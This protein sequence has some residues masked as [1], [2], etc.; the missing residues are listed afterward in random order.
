MKVLCFDIGGT[1]IKYG[2]IE[3]E[4]I[5]YKS[6][7]PTNYQLGQESVSN[8][9]LSVTKELME[10]HDFDGVGVSCAGCV[11][12]DYGEIVAGPENIK[13]FDNWNFKELFE[14]NCG[15]KVVADND[16]NCFGVAEGMTGAARKYNNYLTMTVGTG[17]GGA[18]VVNGEMWR[19]LNFR[20]AEFGRMLIEGG[21]YENLASI[22]ALIRM[23]RIKGLTVG[24]GLDVFNLYDQKNPDAVEVVTTFYHNL[25]VGIANLAYIFNPEAIVIGGGVSNRK[26]FASE[27]KKELKKIMVPSFYDTV[28]IFNAQYGNDGGMMGAYYNFISVNK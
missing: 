6:S 2:V 12:F 14:E 8:R 21:R 15:L 1:D 9:I 25:A 28:K 11:D 18:I 27:L 26:T 16:V 19:G 20:A 10:Q 23:A 3:D 13:E 22:S 24:S 17:I 7:M 5:L 4:K